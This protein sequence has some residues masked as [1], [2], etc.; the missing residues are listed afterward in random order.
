MITAILTAGGTGSRMQNN[1]PKQFITVNEIPII[2]YTLQQFQNNKSIDK[3]IVACIKEWQPV[4]RA[5]SKEFNIS[6]L[7]SIVDGGAT[8][9]ESIQNCFGAIVDGKNDDLILVHDGNRPLVDDAVIERNVDTVREAGATTTYIDIHDG[10]V[11]VDDLL[12]IQNSELD[13]NHI[14]STQTPHSFKYGTLKKVFSNITD[15]S[16]YI[17][18]ADAASKLGYEVALVKGSETNFK[19]T[20]SNDLAIFEAI[21]N[22]RFGNVQ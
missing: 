15:V 22:T 8:G 9:I 1:I 12:N 16:K 13:R 10:I 4:L 20:T 14:K 6:K 18:L 5:Y 19:I 21:I 11:K 7:E 17:S 2:I 3:I